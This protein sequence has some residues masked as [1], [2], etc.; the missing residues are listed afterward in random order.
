MQSI[1]KNKK[2][3]NGNNHINI[4]ENLSL[5]AE[6]AMTPVTMKVNN[7]EKIKKKENESFNLNK[8]IQNLNRNIK[9][10]NNN[11]DIFSERS[12]KIPNNLNSNNKKIN[13]KLTTKVNNKIP[14]NPGIDTW[15]NDKI[16]CNK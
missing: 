13:E 14:N 1:Q 9:S 2:K 3:N 8:Y 10:K 4:F 12:Y 16:N 7:L 11:I 6:K 15:K 5:S